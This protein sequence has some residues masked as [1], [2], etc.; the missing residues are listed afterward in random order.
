MIIISLAM[1][2]SLAAQDPNSAGPAVPG[3]TEGK[4]PDRSST[5]FDLETGA[6]YSTNPFLTFGGDT[7]RAFGR[8]S[9]RAVHSRHSARTN[10]IFSGYGEHIAY[11][12]RYGM[13]QILQATAHHDVALGEQMRV[14]GDLNASVDRGG[15]L[16][17]RFLDLSTTPG[18]SGDPI[19]TPG[20][21]SLGTEV[22]T[23]AGRQYRIGGQ[24]GASMTLSERDSMTLRSGHDRG[25]FRSSGINS[26]YTTSFGSASFDRRLSERA[27]VGAMLSV[28]KS[29]YE[30]SGGART[31]T[32]QLTGKLSLS[33]NTYVDSAIG[34]SFAS[35]DDGTRTLHSTGIAFSTSVCRSGE[36]DQICATASRDQ[37]AAS[38][39]GGVKSLSAG[40][41]YSRQLDARQSIQLSASASRYSSLGN[42]T[43]PFARSSSY[44]RA[45]GS[46]SRKL[47]DRLYGGLNLSA[48]K[49]LQ[50]GSDPKADLNGSAFIRYRIGDLR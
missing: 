10:T 11:T 48:R 26:D 9:L 40:L 2:A 29:N 28:E 12:G 47:Q 49:L 43:S 36:T 41:N 37:S 1:A 22:V 50:R 23:F 21:P 25:Y 18:F 32:P 7:G 38:I 34:V 33:Q 42:F 39:G 20:Y 46:Y 17:T 31:I 6:G 35:I 27:T 45:S 16:G 24:I 30:N 13:Q 14:F 8:V 5:Y 19:T 44:V 3:A 15:Q 4:S